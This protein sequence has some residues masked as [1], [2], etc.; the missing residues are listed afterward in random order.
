MRSLSH[1]V[2]LAALI[3]LPAL[4][5]SLHAQ[6][7]ARHAP[8]PR[9]A[10]R[11]AATPAPRVAVAAATHAVNVPVVLVLDGVTDDSVRTVLVR[12]LANGD[13]IAPLPTGTTDSTAARVQVVESADSLLVLI[14][15]ARTGLARQTHAFR[16]P[17]VPAPRDSAIDDSLHRALVQRTRSRDST[18]ARLATR[19]DSLRELIAQKPKRSWRFWERRDER[20]T[21]AER[22]TRDS[23]LHVTLRLDTLVRANGRADAASTD[24]LRRVLVAADARM[25]DSVRAA[26]R[27]DVHGVADALQR[28]LTGE[29]GI[30]QSRIA[31]VDNG[32]LHVVD[33][34]GAN[35]HV[36]LHGRRALSPAWRH[37]GRA[38]AYSDL[39]DAGTQIGW[40]DLVTGQWKLL[41]A[42]KRGLNITPSY[43]PDD[44]LLA[45]ATAS[46]G[47]TGIVLVP[48]KRDGTFGQLRHV[49]PPRPLDYTSPVFSPDG[50]R[51]AYASARPK[52]PE[53]YSAR[54]DG[55]DE[56]IE[57]PVTDKRKPYRT[58]PDW[59]PDGTAIAFEQQNGDFQVW[60]IGLGARTPRRLTTSG[61]N[62]DPSWAPDSRHLAITTTY[63]TVRG[64]WII[65][66]VTGH[67]RQLTTGRDG[68]LA[69]W[70][71]ILENVHW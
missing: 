42:T 3:A 8:P 21:A 71:P 19:A 35:D 53:I 56:R 33:A 5:V 50:S 6:H 55:S 22:A 12:D 52:R 59:S 44:R 30:A 54:L 57:A 68:R 63:G 9:A 34:D 25:R 28:L 46:D 58:S 51:I 36:V 48:A 69:A 20:A 60:T 65:D 13:A 40:V 24:S 27:W 38:L 15:D 31:Y 70:S 62:E 23:L 66:T 29:R 45:F 4:S 43:S 18:L 14:S 11:R 1:H 37:D 16:L 10:T 41:A 7:A 17:V 67:R 2:A 64:I 32:D 39:T 61:E 49:T 26:R 47:G